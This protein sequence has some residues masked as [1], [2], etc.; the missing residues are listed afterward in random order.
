[1]ETGQSVFDLSVD[2][3]DHSRSSR[4]PTEKRGLAKVQVFRLV[5]TPRCGFEFHR[6]ALACTRTSSAQINIY[7]LVL[8]IPLSPMAVLFHLLHHRRPGFMD[9]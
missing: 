5:Q 1:M 7:W 2:G 8:P 9:L 6:S 3:W 4:G